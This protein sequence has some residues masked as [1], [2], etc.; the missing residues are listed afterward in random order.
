VRV[1]PFQGVIAVVAVYDSL[2]AGGSGVL[3]V[4]N[5]DGNPRPQGAVSH[6]AVPRQ[7]L[8]RRIHGQFCP[9]CRGSIPPEFIFCIHCGRDV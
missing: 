8:F 1:K 3:K 6:D 7:R 9:F 4:P 5:A 2:D